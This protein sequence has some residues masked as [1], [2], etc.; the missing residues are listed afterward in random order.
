MNSKGSTGDSTG[1]R[2]GVNFPYGFPGSF[3]PHQISL[4]PRRTKPP[5]GAKSTP[6]SACQPAAENLKASCDKLEMCYICDRPRT[7]VICS[8]C[9]YKKDNLRVQRPCPLHGRVSSV[10]WPVNDEKTLN[11]DWWK[12]LYAENIWLVVI[13]EGS[14]PD[15]FERM[16]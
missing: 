7:V 12:C 2:L 16:S 14:V 13:F 10:L 3:N 9:G 8:A 6:A 1:G 11:D 5:T 15:G 4:P